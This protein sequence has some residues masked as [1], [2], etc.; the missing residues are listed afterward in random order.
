M[1]VFLA[2]LVDELVLTSVHFL[3]FDCMESLDNCIL[4]QM[5]EYVPINRIVLPDL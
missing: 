2:D 4:L 1:Y 3:S 5:N